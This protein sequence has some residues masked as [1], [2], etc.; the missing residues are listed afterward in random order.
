M[1]AKT[2]L[3]CSNPAYEEG[4][5]LC[6][7]CLLGSAIKA[8]RARKATYA[9]T[10]EKRRAKRAK[11]LCGKSGCVAKAAPGLSMCAAHNKAQNERAARRY[12]ARRDAGVCIDCGRPSGSKARC[13]ACLERA[14]GYQRKRKRR[15][16]ALDS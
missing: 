10:R 2:C 6:E 4:I 8:A 14:K 11:G 16:R 5:E 1:S 15:E 3:Y 13:G 9:G 12:Q 7:A